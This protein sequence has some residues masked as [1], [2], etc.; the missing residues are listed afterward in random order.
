MYVIY[1]VGRRCCNIMRT[2]VG[3]HVH[4]PLLVHAPLSR[5]YWIDLLETL[6]VGDHGVQRRLNSVGCFD[7]GSGSWRTLPP[8]S[9]LRIDLSASVIAGQLYVVERYDGLQM[10][11]SI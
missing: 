9:T 5:Y 4:A 7:T 8:M 6:S 2:T 11:N 3:L 10:L 1:A